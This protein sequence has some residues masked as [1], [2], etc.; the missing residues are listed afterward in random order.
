[1]T[2]PTI[3]FKATNISPDAHLEDYTIDKFETLTKHLGYHEDSTCHVEFERLVAHKSGNVCRAEATLFAHG[4]TFRAESTE[5]TFEQAI[6]TVRKAL[7]HELARA[8]KKH[9]TLIMR[10]RRKVKQWMLFGNK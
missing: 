10:G 2:F 1:M 7:D 3:K 6:D 5:A 8:H 9:D 4:K